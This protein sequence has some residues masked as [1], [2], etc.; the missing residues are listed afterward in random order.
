M[1]QIFHSRMPQSGP[2]YQFSCK[3][4][5]TIEYI[6]E[7][8]HHFNWQSA[9]LKRHGSF[10]QDKPLWD[11]ENAAVVSRAKEI[12]QNGQTLKQHKMTSKETTKTHEQH[13]ATQYFDLV[14]T[15]YTHTKLDI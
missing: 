11:K 9:S 15:L 3:L 6:E 4:P 1:G 12:R 10:R 5:Q 13:L 2:R 14:I 7:Q 8:T